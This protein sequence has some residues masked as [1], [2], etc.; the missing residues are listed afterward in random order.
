MASTNTTSV[1]N[2]KNLKDFKFHVKGNNG[3]TVWER[4][5]CFAQFLKHVNESGSTY[6]RL[7]LSPIDRDV[8]IKDPFTGENRTMLMFASN[9][10][11]G[12]ANHPYIK[13]KVKA[14]IDEYGVGLGGPPLLNGY[15]KLMQELEER[16]ADLKHHE[17]AMVFPTGYTSNVGLIT[18][19]VKE[20]DKVIYDQLSHASFLDGMHM[21]NAQSEVFD[22]NNL[23]QLESLLR[24]EQDCANNIFVGVEGVYSMDGDLAPLDKITKLCKQYKAIILLDDAHGTGVLGSDGSGTA[25]HFNCQNDIDITMGTFSKAFAMTG[26]FLAGPKDIIDSIRYLGRTYMFS[27][28]LPPVSLAVVSAGIDLIEKKPELRDK[29]LYNARYATQKLTPLGLCATPRA[30]IISVKVPEWIDIRKLNYKIH[31]QGIFL[32]SIEY[33]AVPQDQQ[34][35]RISITTRHTEQ[36]IDFLADTLYQV[37]NDKDCVVKTEEVA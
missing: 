7:I 13:K 29:L 28:A 18:S 1:L 30:A 14:A 32:N 10:Y 23:D 26:G 11:L 25:K 4:A 35:L 31:Q 17:S 8:I 27:A 20:G 24:K 22:H 16:L 21:A 36:D 33:P 34:R 37:F 9:N 6:S 2:E 15:T 12:F 5:N 19:L 3:N